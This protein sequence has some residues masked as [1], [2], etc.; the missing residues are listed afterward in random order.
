MLGSIFSYNLNANKKVVSPYCKK[1]RKSTDGHFK[2]KILNYTKDR[3]RVC[4]SNFVTLDL[5]IF[6]QK[7]LYPSCPVVPLL[8]DL[9]C[10]NC[11][12]GS[13]VPVGKKL[14]AA[15]PS[16]GAIFLLE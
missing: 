3:H 13:S 4:D 8:W 12:V 9:N 16:G 11:P 1:I 15:P 6:L 5:V 7:I 2:Q 14:S 10:G